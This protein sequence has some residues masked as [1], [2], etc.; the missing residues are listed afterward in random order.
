MESK[1]IIIRGNSEAEKQQLRK[2]SKITWG[3]E[4]YWFLKMSFAG[5]C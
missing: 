1:L 4:L 2:N 3:M 5:K